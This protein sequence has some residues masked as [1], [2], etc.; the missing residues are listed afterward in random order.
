MEISVKRGHPQEQKT[1]CLIVGVHAGK[2]LSS[3]AEAIDKAL[4][5]TLTIPALCCHDMPCLAAGVPGAR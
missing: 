1:A 2:K 4:G 5:G 3:A